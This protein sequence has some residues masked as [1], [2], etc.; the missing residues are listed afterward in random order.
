MPKGPQFTYSL[1]HTDE[2]VERGRRIWTE[3]FPLH[4]KLCPKGLKEGS[5]VCLTYGDYYD[6]ARVFFEK[7]RFQTFTGV[8]SRCIQHPVSPS[9]IKEIH[10]RLEKH[11]ELY[12]PSRIEALI[13]GERL[14]FV[15]NVAIST[16]GK[17]CMQREYTLLKKLGH[18]FSWP[19]LP[20]VYGL[21]A[22]VV[23]HDN[24]EFSMFLGAW[25]E[26]YHEFHLSENRADE[27]ITIV[28]WDPING[29]FELPQELFLNLYRQAAMILTCYYNLETFEQIFPWYHAAG[30]FIVKI[31]N[32]TLDMKLISVRHYAPM[33]ENREPDPKSMVEAMLVFLLNLSL[34]MRLDRMDGVGDLVWADDRAVAGTLK[35]FFD[36]LAQKASSDP[37][38]APL[39]VFFK[40]YLLSRTQ[41]DLFDVSEAIVSI[42]RP[43][44]PETALTRKHLKQHI[45]SVYEAIRYF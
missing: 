21:G 23:G 7:D 29:N 6:A 33:V 22:V 40:E 20:A 18:D 9:D 10:I 43:E 1:S 44:A 17:R 11:G 19:Y 35:G 38:A 37:L 45:A 41:S 8:V 36:G 12:H 27:K 4:R 25:H 16:A 2:P 26:G 5:G 3:P 30:D 24:L 13:D 15:L 31:Q 32:N 39:S 42:Y 28:V 14:S 34:R